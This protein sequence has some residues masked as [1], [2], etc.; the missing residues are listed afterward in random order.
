MASR[1]VGYIDLERRRDRRREITMDA[2]LDD[3]DIRILDIGLSGFG[4]DGAFERHDKTIWPECDRR[5][6]LR[7]TDYRDREV[8]VLVKITSVDTETG[9]FG[10]GFIEISGLA[11][12]VIQDLMLHRDL[13]AAAR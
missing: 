12:D 3:Q 6:E 13:R 2:K 7:F 11:F 10:G 9:R 5:T 4:A 8:L 1:F